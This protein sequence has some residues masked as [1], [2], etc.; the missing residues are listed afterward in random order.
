M[1]LREANI[2][3]NCDEIFKGVVCP[4]CAACSWHP[5]STWILPIA[6]DDRP[7]LVGSRGARDEEAR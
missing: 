3:L 1:K 6:P 2:C 7:L 5:L 4:N